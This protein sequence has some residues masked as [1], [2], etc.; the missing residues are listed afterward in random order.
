[1]HLGAMATIG[2]MKLPNL[3]HVI[4]NNGVHESVGGQPSGG[5]D[6]DFTCIAK[7][8]GYNTLEREIRNENELSAALDRFILTRESEKSFFMDVRVSM[9]MREGLGPLNTS[10]GSCKKAFMEKMASKM[11]RGIL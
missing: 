8:T 2:K 7:S 1:M 3:L 10:L 11:E 4:L 9:G 6:I 5:Y